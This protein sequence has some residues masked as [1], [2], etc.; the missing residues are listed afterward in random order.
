MVS[1]N[2]FMPNLISNCNLV[3]IV[4]YLFRNNLLF[5]WTR[6]TT[7]HI[8]RCA[9]LPPTRRYGHTMVDVHLLLNGN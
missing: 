3:V 6:I 4:I 5:S 2:R 7:D 1:H 9:P 8:L